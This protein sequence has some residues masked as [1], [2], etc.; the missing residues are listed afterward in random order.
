MP[1]SAAA[2]GVRCS[3]RSSFFAAASTSGGILASAIAFS[4]SARS[5]LLEPSLAQLALDGRHLLAQQ[6]L[7]LA[8][9]ERGLGL[10]ADLGRQAQHLQ[11]MGE[12]L[13]HLVEPRHEVGGL[14]D[15]LLLRRRGVE[16]G[17][18]RGRPACRATLVASTVWRSSGGTCGSRSSD[19]A[20]LLL[21]HMEARLD[22][23]RRRGRLGE[24]QAAGQQEGVAFDEVGDTEALDALADQMVAAFGAGDVA[25]DVGDRADAVEIVR[26]RDRPSRGRAA[27]RSR[28]GAARARPAGRRRWS[29][30]GRA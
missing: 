28:S 3:R 2:S 30:P 10:A 7:A 17:R 15:V 1:Y 13:R 22:L 16:V 19:L 27:A 14:E 4:R 6:H 20:H 8:R 26:A 29:R 25:Q 11:P 18:R 9:I 24:V 5:C 23:G 21:Q 12:Q